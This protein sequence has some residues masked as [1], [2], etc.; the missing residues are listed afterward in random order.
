MRAALG[1]SEDGRVNGRATADGQIRLLE[2]H[3]LAVSFTRSRVALC[4]NGAMLG[5]S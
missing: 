3:E 4:A 1:P 5:F 2:A